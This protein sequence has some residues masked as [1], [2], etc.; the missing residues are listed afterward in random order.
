MALWEVTQL[1]ERRRSMSIRL[2]GL[3][4]SWEALHDELDGIARLVRDALGAD[5][6]AINLLVD[7]FQVSAGGTSGSHAPVPR[8]MGICSTALDAHP[9]D[10]LIEIPDT[11]LDPALAGNPSVDGSLAA[12]RFY[13]AAPL[14]G[15]HGLVLGT[16]CAWSMTPQH[17]DD[18]GRVLL[19][20]LG[21]AVVNVLDER[22]R[23]LVPDVSGALRPA[24]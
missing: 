24:R 1:V 2:Y 11:R 5:G 13:A 7:D 19:R 14:V 10:D 8:S 4:R 16:L 6:A 21:R 23:A 18:R 12:V 3:D 22:R 15:K 20:Q 9:E 17:L